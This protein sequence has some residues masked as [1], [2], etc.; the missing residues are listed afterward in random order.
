MHAAGRQAQARFRRCDG[1][2]FC[3]V[4]QRDRR[5]GPATAEVVG[6]GRHKP[7]DPAKYRPQ[8]AA[9]GNR[10]VADV[11]SCVGEFGPEELARRLGFKARGEPVLRVFVLARYGAHFSGFAGLDVR[12][13]WADWAHFEKIRRGDSEASV[14]A[15]AQQVEMEI[16]AV[17]QYIAPESLALPLPDLAIVVNPSV[18]PSHLGG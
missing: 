5:D 6:A 8:P 15:L 2:R 14:A 3:G 4:R 1:Y 9:E 18:R 10:W 13:V 16:A 17:Q 12:A 11:Y 7:Q